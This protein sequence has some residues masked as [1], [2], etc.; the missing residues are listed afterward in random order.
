MDNL[1]VVGIAVALLVPFAGNTLGAALVFL[2]RHGM[3][4]RFSKALLGFA[5]GRHDSRQ[6]VESHHPGSRGG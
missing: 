6:C 5:G 2:M 4:E 3:S 1:A